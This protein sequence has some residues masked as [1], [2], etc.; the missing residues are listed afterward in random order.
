MSVDFCVRVEYYIHTV[1]VND[2]LSMSCLTQHISPCQKNVRACVCSCRGTSQAKMSNS[3]RVIGCRKEGPPL[4]CV[5]SRVSNAVV[6][7]RDD[8]MGMHRWSY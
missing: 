6:S 1:Y 3:Y 8:L 4:S 7:R 5:D 2:V